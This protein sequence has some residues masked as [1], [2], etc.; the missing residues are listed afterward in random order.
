MEP[1]MELSDP[2]GSCKPAFSSLMSLDEDLG[3]SVSPW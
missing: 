2:E 1:I 3:V